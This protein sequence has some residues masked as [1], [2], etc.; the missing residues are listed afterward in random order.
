MCGVLGETA[1]AQ[2][3]F[4]R[5]VVRDA[6]NEEPIPYASVEMLPARRGAITDSLGM[7]SLNTTG[8]K[9]DSVVVS[10]VGYSR[11]AIAVSA[12]KDSGYITINL[13]RA[14]SKTVFVKTKAN[15]GLILWRKVVR[16]K[17]QNDKTRF[18][19][20][21]YEIHNKLELDLNRVNKEKLAEMRLMKNFT[22]ILNNIDTTEGSPILPVFL[23][24]TL[25]DYYYQ[26]KPLRRREVIKASKTNGINNESVTKNLGN[27]YQNVNVYANFIPVFD[28]QFVSP[29]S[30]NG[31]AFYN[32]GVPDTIMEN[33]RRFFHWTF[34]AKHKGESTFEGDAWVHDTTFAIQRIQLR[35]TGNSPVNFVE[36][37]SIY[38]DFR[39]LN[40][41]LWFLSKD[42]FIAD[43][44]PIGKE[45]FGMKGRKTT[46]YRN[47]EIN[48]AN[49]ATQLAKN[50]LS[51]EVIV[52]PNAE[53][54]PDSFWT[55][56]RHEVLSK[57]EASVYKM[58][59][60]LQQMP[61]FKKYTNTVTFLTTGYKPIGN[62]EIG[63]WFNWI[64]ANAWEGFR[65]RFDLGTTPGFNKKMYLHGYL[66]YGF[67]DQKFKGKAEGYYFIKKN[68]RQY[69]HATYLNDLDNGQNYYDEVSLDNI[70]SLAVRK[71]GIPIKF[72]KVQMQELEYFNSTASGFSAKVEV[73]RKLFTP[74]QNLPAKEYFTNG[75][76]DPINN[77]ETSVRLRF[78]YLERFLDGNYFRTSLGSEFPI[79]ELRYSKGWSGV[80][81]SQYNYNK[82]DFRINDFHKIPPLGTL[83]YSVYG[84]KLYG[85]LPYMLLNVAPGNEIYYYNKYAFNLMARFEYITDQYVGAGVEHNIGPG[86]FKYIGITR[87]LKLRQFWNIKTLAGNLTDANR[88]LNFVPNHPFSDLSGKLYTEVGTGIDNILKVLRLDLVWRLSPRPLSAPQASRFGVFGSFRV[89][90]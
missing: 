46:T 64:T 25:S 30:D 74:L 41:S 11:K 3:V 82:F 88:Q 79:V 66:A 75:S 40:D 34:T 70:F 45:K 16:H 80:F 81:G 26:R 55:S 54:K 49:V 39:Q 58:I 47:I 5:G 32:Y 84:G 31:D 73:R 52:L 85:T 14:V 89:A 76:G 2:P 71:Q 15:W 20:Y 8:V 63:P 60:T 69:V 61:L 38:Q 62:Y 37:L 27:M 67:G 90:F 87:K 10:Y 9:V 78:A 4:L 18:A 57:N 12:F 48:T 6:H 51:E 53:E 50:K 29:L 33:G 21:G 7:F 35:I 43:I 44:F 65:M 86:L 24:E 36:N 22:F 23:T 28:K 19:S 72:M 77:F 59:D 83:E 13:D 56:K 17:L 68:P 1:L 42:K